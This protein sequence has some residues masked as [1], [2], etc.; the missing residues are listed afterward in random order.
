MKK[1]VLKSS[2]FVVLFALVFSAC[3]PSSGVVGAGGKVSADEF[4]QKL[5]AT[6]N[7]Q[8]VDVRTPG[9][10]SEGRL[11][12]ALNID[13]NGDAFESEINKLDKSKPTFV[14]CLSGGRSSEAAEKMK[15]LGFK[16]IYEM[17]G[18]IR[19]WLNGNKPLA[20]EATAAPVSDGMSVLDFENQLKTDKLVL[21]DFNAPWCAPCKRMAPMFEELSTELKDKLILIKINA[22]DNKGLANA[23]KIENL[24]TILLYK[25]GTIVWKHEGEVEK[26]ELLKTINQN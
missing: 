16:E 23:M 22:D 26:A 8:L 4:E 6:E 19:A 5:K 25:N 24:P 21:V 10:Y 18:G 14:Y 2:A 13:W 3:K 9:E 11:L 1:I 17:Q 20:T 12:N 15:E 7:A